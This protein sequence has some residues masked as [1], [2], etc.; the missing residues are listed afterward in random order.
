MHLPNTLALRIPARKYH[1]HG[2]TSTGMTGLVEDLPWESMTATVLEEL[3]F[4]ILEEMGA[5][6]V[7]WRSAEDKITTADGGRDIEAT[8]HLPTPDDDIEPQTWWIEC[9]Q[10]QRPVSPSVV[11]ESILNSTAHSN[12]TNFIVATNSRFSNPTRDWVAAHN[13]RRL[14]PT[15]KL[16]DRRRLQSLVAKYPSAAARTLVSA[17]SVKERTEFLG[18]YFFENS[19]VPTEL[20]FRSLLAG[21]DWC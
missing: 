20:E 7:V 16:W 9:K 3:T 15:V 8:F 4:A 14:G 21:R 6:Q 5:T 1:D 2:N 17:L 10:R 13:M 12:V 11:K 18:S 19:R